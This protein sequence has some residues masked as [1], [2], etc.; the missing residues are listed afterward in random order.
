MR[1]AIEGTL[2][3]I[4]NRES[5]LGSRFVGLMRSAG[6][7]LGVGATVGAVG[8]GLAHLESRSPLVR[9]ID[10]PVAPRPG[11]EGLRILHISDLHM[12]NRQ[13]FLVDFLHRVAAEEDFDMVVSTGDNLGGADGYALLVDAL[14]PLLKKPGVF[15]LG[16]NDY[17]SPSHTPWVQYLDPNH[18]NS[19]IDRYPG[20]PDLPWLDMVR[21][22][23]EAGWLDLSNQSAAIEIPVPGS[24]STAQ[25]IAEGIPVSG[26]SPE[27]LVA[28]VGVDDPHIHR[29]RI[30]PLVQ[31]WMDPSALRIAVTHSPYRRVLD[32]FTRDHADLILAGHTHGGQIRVPGVGALVTNCDL[33]RQHG[34]GLN[35]WQA[36]S[37]GSWLHV[38]AGLGTSRTAPVRLFCRPEVSILD[39]HP[40]TQSL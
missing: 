40:A 5:V 15:V 10:V 28:L 34:R 20:A 19:A 12:F 1:Q 31:Q 33:P 8:V 30:P 35:L 25:L 9:H 2:E 14:Q 16:S 23:T 4:G 39:V 18:H 6:A 26:A 3:D 21:M 11:L 37:E 36:G 22:M 27:T 17:Y 32:E 24:Q 13:Q 29:D 7:I 38:S